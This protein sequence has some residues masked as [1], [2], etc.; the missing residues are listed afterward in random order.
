M[1]SSLTFQKL[2]FFHGT[3]DM[4]YFAL[5]LGGTINKMNVRDLGGDSWLPMVTL[6]IL[7]VWAPTEYFRLRFGYSGNIK[8]SFSEVIAFL[9]FS[10][11]VILL[12][13]A[14]FIYILAPP[15]LPHERFCIIVNIG[16][17]I[18]EFINGCILVRRFMKM[19]AA[20]FYLRTAPILDK[21]F[22]K[23]YAGADDI[24]SV[25]EI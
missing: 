4:V 19:H 24:M 10:F 2:L 18:V 11:F 21:N 6:I 16:F 25:R 15:M 5:M 23:K 17:I 12:S 22:Q 9:A 7:G 14:P 13:G 3:Y 8:E 20:A 1:T